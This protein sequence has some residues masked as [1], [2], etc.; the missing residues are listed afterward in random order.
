MKL[1]NLAKLD[2]LIYFNIN[3]L[4]AL[5]KTASKKSLE[6]S[7]Y[8]WLKNGELISLKKG[9]YITK[10]NYLKYYQNPK[11]SEFLAGI[12]KYPSYLSLDYVLSKYNILTQGTYG[13][14][15]I[16]LKTGSIVKNKINTFVYRN[17]KKSMYWGFNKKY[18]LNYEFFEASKEKAL[19]DYL[20]YKKRKLGVN[21]NKRNL[22]LDFRLNLENF[23]K[24]DFDKLNFMAHKTNSPKL[25]KIIK[26]ITKNA[27]YT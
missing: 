6:L 10:K 12:I 5:N 15:S 11:Y 26:N 18:F 8:H 24:K 7:I 1:I 17:I 3:T 20:Y 22:V 14:T 4:L 23:T 13:I 25:L 19:L 2:N 27:P 16:S 9:F 21:F